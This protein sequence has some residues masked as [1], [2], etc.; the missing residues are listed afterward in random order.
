VQDLLWVPYVTTVSELFR[1]A[2]NGFW[3]SD[4]GFMIAED[5]SLWKKKCG[6]FLLKVSCCFR[7][8]IPTIYAASLAASRRH[9]QSFPISCWWTLQFFLSS[10][11]NGMKFWITRRINMYFPF[12]ISTD[13]T[14]NNCQAFIAVYTLDSNGYIYA[15]LWLTSVNE[16]QGSR[17]HAYTI[18]TPVKQFSVT[19][20]RFLTCRYLDYLLETSR[21][22]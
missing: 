17:W 11:H 18:G 14:L 9:I 3:I 15:L 16:R 8:H 20:S 13:N 4:V 22:T 19:N 6:K 2:L 21:E 10:L 5:V 7:I 12:A 1:N